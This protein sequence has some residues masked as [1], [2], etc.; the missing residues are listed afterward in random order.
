MDTEEWHFRASLSPMEPGRVVRRKLL[1]KRLL[2]WSRS[3]LGD[4]RSRLRRWESLV[5]GALLLPASVWWD[6]GEYHVQLFH[7]YCWAGLQL[8]AEL[9]L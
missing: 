4:P 5:V 2:E 3:Q 9:S 8:S 7:S 1:G 6:G